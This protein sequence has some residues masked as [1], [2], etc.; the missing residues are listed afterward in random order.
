MESEEVQIYS[1]GDEE[2]THE[3]ALEVLNTCHTRGFEIIV[4]RLMSHR[5]QDPHNMVDN[6]SVNKDTYEDFL[7]FV[8]AAQTMIELRDMENIV[9]NAM[10]SHD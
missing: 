9:K 10:D 5:Y 6:Q 3:E 2:I 1:V 4:N 7:G 8:G